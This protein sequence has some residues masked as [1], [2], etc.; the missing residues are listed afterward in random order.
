MNNE[1]VKV[2]LVPGIT[3]DAPKTETKSQYKEGDKYIVIN[4][5][6][7]YVK[8]RDG[9]L[10]TKKAKSLDD[11]SMAWVGES[12]N[13]RFKPILDPHNQKI[14]SI[15]IKQSNRFNILYTIAETF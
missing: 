14:R 3:I 1:T 11:I 4:P 10:D 6:E 12:P 13:D 7:P 15:S 8:A 5:K 2:E 9:E